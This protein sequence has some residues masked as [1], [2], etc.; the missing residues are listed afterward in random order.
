MVGAA[1]DAGDARGKFRVREELLSAGHAGPGSSS[2]CAAVA[3]SAVVRATRGLVGRSSTLTRR[4]THPV[5]VPRPVA[6]R[7]GA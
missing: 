6:P 3:G 2:G 5:R 1:V 7:L 4:D